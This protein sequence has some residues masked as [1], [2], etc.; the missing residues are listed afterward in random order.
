MSDTGARRRATRPRGAF[1]RSLTGA[2]VAV[3]SESLVGTLRQFADEDLIEV[4]GDEV[5]IA[6]V[7]RLCRHVHGCLTGIKAERGGCEDA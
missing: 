1:G 3:A 2:S 5:R 7:E 6:E 4:A